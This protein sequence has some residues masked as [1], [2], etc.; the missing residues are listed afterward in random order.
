MT[1]TGRAPRILVLKDSEVVLGV[2]S[3][4]MDRMP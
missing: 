1:P 2:R 3:D 4:L